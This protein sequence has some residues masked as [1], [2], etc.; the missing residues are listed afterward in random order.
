MNAERQRIVAIVEGFELESVPF[1][2]LRN[3]NDFP[4]SKGTTLTPAVRANYV[5]KG[6]NARDIEPLVEGNGWH[7]MTKIRLLILEVAW[8]WSTSPMIGQSSRAKFASASILSWVA[9]AGVTS[10]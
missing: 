5:S 8:M 10:S 9:A 2:I 6:L 4:V 7:D 1:T 3:D